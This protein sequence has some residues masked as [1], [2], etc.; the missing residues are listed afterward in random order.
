MNR[1]TL[2][3][4]AG[5]ACASA[6]AAPM[7]NR[8]SFQLFAQSPRKYSARAIELVH[9]STVIDMLNDFGGDW[10]SVLAP[11]EKQDKN[12]WFFDPTLFKAENFEVF[13]QSGL[14]VLHTGVGFAVPN[15][16]EIALKYFA[17]WNGFLAHHSEW[18]MRIDSPDRLNAVKGSGKLGII[19]GLQNADHFRTLDDID[20]FYSLGQRVSQLTYNARNLI[21]SGSTERN[22]DGLSDFGISVVQRMNALGMAVDVSHC[23]DQTSLDTCKFSKAPVLITHSNCRALNPGHPRCKTDEMIKRMAATGGVMG[24]TSFR[25]FVKNSDPTTIDHVIDHFDHVARLVGVEHVGVGNDSELQPDDS[26]SLEDRKKLQAGFKSSYGFREKFY[27]DGLNHP[28]RA[29]DLTEALIRRKYSDNDIEMILGGNF[30]RAL[31]QIWKP[32]PGNAAQ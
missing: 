2:L 17:S 7:V 16:Y 19:L 14:T 26:M 23:G 18:L 8:N 4:A 32:I 3:K 13:R 10:N 31:N 11:G 28:Q 25:S 9:R 24:I 5:A 6:I 12:P 29:F 20:Y 21:G 15:L 22:D 1:R 30:K 27:I